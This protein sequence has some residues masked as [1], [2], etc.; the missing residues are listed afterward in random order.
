MDTHRYNKLSKSLH[1]DLDLGIRVPILR[2]DFSPRDMEINSMCDSK[3]PHDLGS[4]GT[5]L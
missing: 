1:I 2:F 3:Y 4:H 5:T